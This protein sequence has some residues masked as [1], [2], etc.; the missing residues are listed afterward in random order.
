MSGF[1]PS[2][3]HEYFNDRGIGPR[4]TTE[5]RN[6]SLLSDF[7]GTVEIVM[8][9][10]P[11]YGLNL[12][13][14]N[15]FP[16]ERTPTLSFYDGKGTRFRVPDAR[17]TETS[18]LPFAGK[19]YKSGDTEGYIWSARFALA[20]DLGVDKIRM[21]WWTWEGSEEIGVDVVRFSLSINGRFFTGSP[22]NDM[23]S[24]PGE[25]SSDSQSSQ[26][27]SFEDLDCPPT[28]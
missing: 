10:L 17:I 25:S 20:T 8:Y 6:L 18:L 5:W 14:D 21:R 1:R 24:L 16:P 7:V 22:A 26:I 3:G 28:C 23:I 9:L 11:S 27:E 12:H 2:I 15:R 13:A 19:I 4:I